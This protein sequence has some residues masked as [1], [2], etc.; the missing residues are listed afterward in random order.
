MKLKAIYLDYDMTRQYNS[1][2]WCKAVPNASATN[3]KASPISSLTKV[4]LIMFSGAHSIMHLNKI[5]PKRVDYQ[6]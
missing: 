4:M 6:Q 5:C 1:S 3:K 2:Q